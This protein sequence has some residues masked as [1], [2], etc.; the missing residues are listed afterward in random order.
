MSRSKRSGNKPGSA[1]R[2]RASAA[3]P[4]A[5]QK[6]AAEERELAGRKHTSHETSRFLRGDRIQPKRIDGSET[7]AD[8]IEGTFLAYNAARLREG[9]QLFADFNGKGH[10]PMVVMS[11]K[12]FSPRL[13]GTYEFFTDQH[14]VVTHI[15]AHGIQ[16]STKIV[17]RR[18]AAH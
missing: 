10:V 8:L 6:R 13:L 1:P 15:M 17:K 7:A 3:G 18:E 11:E 16:G 5:E 2:K 12:L 4:K 14:G 9:S